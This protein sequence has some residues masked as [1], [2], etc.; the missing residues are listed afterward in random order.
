V[1][2]RPAPEIQSGITSPRSL[3]S[4]RRRARQRRRRAQRE[5]PRPTKRAS[6]PRVS[7]IRNPLPP[8]PPGAR[9][10]RATE[11]E[12]IRRET[13]RR[14]QPKTSGLSF[15]PTAF[16]KF[17]GEEAGAAKTEAG[18]IARGLPKAGYSYAKRSSSKEA[19][20]KYGFLAP[21]GVLMEDQAEYVK[22]KYG[23]LA[24]GG[25]P[26]RETVEQIKR[27]PI[28]TL[29]D[30]LAPLSVGKGAI[31]RTKLAATAKGGPVKRY[32]A[33]KAL[34][35]PRVLKSGEAEAQFPASPSAI[36]RDLQKARDVVS[37]K[38]GTAPARIA[39][40][41]ARQM[42]VD[43]QRRQ[44]AFAGDVKKV[45]DVPRK[46]RA[47]VFYEAQ[48]PK[49][50]R[51]GEGLER[52]EATLRERS[53]K[54][55]NLAQTRVRK[56]AERRLADLDEKYETLV[57]RVARSRNR[58]RGGIR[59]GNMPKVSAD[60]RDLAEQKIAEMVE[61]HPDLPA[62]RM[63]REREDL[64]E[65][66]S[67]IGEASIEGRP[68]PMGQPRSARRLA[69]QAERVK[70]SR[71]HPYDPTEAVGAIERLEAE[72]QRIFEDAGKLRPE[73]AEAAKG[74]FARELGYEDTAG[75][76][77]IGHRT[78]EAPRALQRLG[79]TR[80]TSRFIGP[81]KTPPGIGQQRTGAAFRSGKLRADPRI[82]IEDWQHAQRFEFQNI[83]RRELAKFA[84]PEV[85]ARLQ[86]GERPP[87][88]GYVVNPEGHRLPRAWKEA[89]PRK[90]AAEEGIDLEGIVAGDLEEYIR[91]Y[92]ARAGTRDAAELVSKSGRGSVV[93]VD[94][95][96]VQNSSTSSRT[97]PAYRSAAPPQSA[98]RATSS[99]TS[100]VS[101]RS[102][103]IPATSRR[104]GSAT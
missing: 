60:I 29:L 63:I 57:A 32:R 103:R 4:E 46:A 24:P 10:T 93:W 51:R 54:L 92:I 7:P 17:L 74:K 99:T 6:V 25:R 96:N 62:S 73:T 81:A 49:A 33:S 102:T 9:R 65:A 45:T 79:Q 90:L 89:D 36:T 35:R 22:H 94:E 47:G 50:A 82:A 42:R 28:S 80:V 52:V 38:L 76:G 14:Y 72:R 75:A 98:K 53:T 64:R 48:L 16:L 13:A 30:I 34:P 77:Y 85:T 31:R 41:R 67:A 71:E 18:A 55:T 8:E 58:L 19:R 104:T 1:A 40:Q 91:N 27:E 83:A 66:L 23:P 70:R 21:L 20:A 5:A 37:T 78:K 100:P 84:D 2:R 68:S 88:N 87:R 97:A 86:R 39:K 15:D 101:R 43:L 95:K 26:A 11:R 12:R 3:P 56:R 69:V 59:R 44:A 61:K